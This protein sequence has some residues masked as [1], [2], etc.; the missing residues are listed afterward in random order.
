M[1]TVLCFPFAHT[2]EFFLSQLHLNTDMKVTFL[3]IK[4]GSGNSIKL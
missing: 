1:E 2:W 4:F 3:F